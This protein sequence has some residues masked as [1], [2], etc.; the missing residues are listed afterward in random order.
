M[1]EGEKEGKKEK[2]AMGEKGS[3]RAGQALLA[4]LR[5]TAVRYN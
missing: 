5:V 2:I 3:P 1:E 4:V